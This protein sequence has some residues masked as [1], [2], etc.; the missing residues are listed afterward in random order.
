MVRPMLL[1]TVLLALVSLSAC[2]F[3]INVG[4]RPDLASARDAA[5][6]LDLRWV[7]LTRVNE[8]LDIA[9]DQP[10][11]DPPLDATVEAAV[12]TAQPDQ[13]PI[14]G[15]QPDSSLTP[16]A[17]LGR[18]VITLAGS[19]AAGAADGPAAAAQFSVPEGIAVDSVGRVYVADTGNNRIRVI[20]N[21]QVST[22]AGSAAG[23]QDGPLAQARFARPQG[24]AVDSTGRVFVADGANYVV[25]QIEAGQ[26]ST[27]AGSSRGL[28]D[29]PLLQAR[30]KQ[31]YR[32]CVGT[33]GK[34]YVSDR[35][36]H[37]IRQIDNGWVSTVAGN[38]WPGSGNGAGNKARFRYPGGV[39]ADTFGVV[40]VADTI[41]D[42]VRLISLGQVSTLGGSKGGFADGPLS[43]A[44]FNSPRGITL[45]S[46][47]QIFVADTHN[48]RVR[49]IAAGQVTTYAGQGTPNYADGPAASAMFNGLSDLAL[50]SQG[51]VYVA[52]TQ[53]NRIRVIL[54]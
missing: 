40:Y 4:N 16:D 41:N 22:L 18:R 5:P 12:D 20:H 27:L 1:L 53:S 14:D 52:D 19:G 45:D 48:H 42:R 36:S 54:P 11:V 38:G 8:D 28:K 23:Y 51:R 49:L 6:G 37:A 10:V 7:D 3:G 25:R 29:G 46:A 35:N 33:G 9:E 2:E 24:V 21:G 13:T 32:V 26:V 50:D 47:G 44:R 31:P 43:L 15:A 30:F 17:G 34:L 39:A